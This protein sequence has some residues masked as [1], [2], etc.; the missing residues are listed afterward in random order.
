MSETEKQFRAVG[1]EKRRKGGKYVISWEH[2]EHGRV[3]FWVGDVE[4]Q[5]DLWLMGYEAGKKVTD[6]Q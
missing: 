1:W 2:P 5:M 4:T 3:Y 6:E